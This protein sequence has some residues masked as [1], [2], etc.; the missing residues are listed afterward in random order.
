VR[1]VEGTLWNDLPHLVPEQ[2][3]D[4]DPSRR[5]YSLGS[6]TCCQLLA[7]ASTKQLITLF[8][9]RTFHGMIVQ[10][11][12]AKVVERSSIRS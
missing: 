1:T 8:N 9:C 5:L 7:C 2:P 4:E 10:A 3:E 11:L 12:S 6:R